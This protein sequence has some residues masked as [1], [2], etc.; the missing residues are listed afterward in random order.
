[1][2]VEEQKET[3]KINALRKEKKYKKID[4]A[5]FVTNLDQES[6]NNTL[7]VYDRFE[8]S[9]KDGLWR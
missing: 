9:N 2:I 5:A 1:M 6:N 8:L 7:T 3:N 4:K